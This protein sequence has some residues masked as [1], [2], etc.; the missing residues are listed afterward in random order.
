[1]AAHPLFSGR[2]RKDWARGLEMLPSPHKVQV[3]PKVATGSG[4]HKAPVGGWPEWLTAAAWRCVCGAFKPPRHQP[5]S[6][7]QPRAALEAH[8]PHCWPHRHRTRWDKSS[9][10]EG[11]GAEGRR[12]HEGSTVRCLWVIGCADEPEIH[13]GVQMAGWSLSKT[14]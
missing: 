13:Q 1:M 9:R 4:S 3:D 12:L 8:L 10:S 6:P 11:Q 2:L 7:R 14:N 5:R